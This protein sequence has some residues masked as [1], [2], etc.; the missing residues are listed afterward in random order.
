MKFGE[1]WQLKEKKYEDWDAEN[2]TIVILAIKD[3]IVYYQYTDDL[4]FMFDTPNKGCSESRKEF[5]L[6]FKKCSN[7]DLNFWVNKA[8]ERI[9]KNKLSRS[10]YVDLSEFKV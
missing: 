7:Q 1:I 10:K 4:H 3:D 8:K 9:K 6:D 5:L 2:T